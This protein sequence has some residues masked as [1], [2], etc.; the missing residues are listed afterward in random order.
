V[1]GRIKEEFRNI[2]IQLKRGSGR[3]KGAG[4]EI[5]FKV[6]YFKRKINL[7][8][9]GLAGMVFFSRSYRRQR[10]RLVSE[11]TDSPVKEPSG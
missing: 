6:C 11:W 3:G 8:G 10:L 9:K 5:E 7:D 1:A 2:F 4:T